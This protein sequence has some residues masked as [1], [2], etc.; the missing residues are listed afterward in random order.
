MALKDIEH[1]VVVMMENRSFDSL[2][3]WLYDNKTNPPPHNIPPQSPTTFE[4]LT[5]KT[6]FNLNNNNT[7]IYANRPPK[8]WPSAS[9][10]PTPDPH[11]EFDH[12][13]TQIFGTASPA[14]GAKADMSGFLRDYASTDAGTASAEQIMQSYGPQEANVINDLARNFAVC[15]H[16]FASAPS[17]TWPNRGFV[18]SGSSDGHINNDDY[19][20]YN[21]PTIFNILEDQG[22]TW[23]VF[24][25]TTLMPS[26]T[27]GQFLPQLGDL[28][29]HFYKYETFEKLCKATGNATPATKLPAYS[30]IEPRFTPELGLFEVDYPSDYHPPHNVCRGEQFLASVYQAVQSSP[31]RDKILLIIT[32]DEHGGCYDHVTPPTGAIAP[33]PGAVSNDGKFKFDRYGVRVPAIVISSYVQPGTVFRASPG[34]APYDHTS[35]LATLRDWLT[36]ASDP[37]KP[38]LPSPRIQKA[39]TLDRVLVL[40]DT[41]KNTTWPDISA[42]CTVGEDDKSLQTPL[43]S[44]QK[45]LIA[46]AIRQ[47]S[48]TPTDAATGAAAAQQ[49]KSLQTY[50]HAI[51]LLH[52][53]QE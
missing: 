39:P 28:D 16:W 46:T 7:P 19:E 5:E 24:H 49:A 29:G 10:V 22:K 11:E 6:Y 51:N 44:V 31:Y 43:N 26:L 37:K 13:T 32:F 53:S 4:G 20:L 23:G 14:A 47:N 52:P 34:E 12:I 17:Q 40:S 27:L 45:S 18:H 48:D 35:I 38:F 41:N 25:D 1:V 15:D 21:I 2:L 33:K 30:F 3:G 9:T 36:L 42:Q 50:Q 8:G